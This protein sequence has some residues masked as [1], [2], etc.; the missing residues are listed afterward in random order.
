MHSD[1]AVLPCATNG[2]CWTISHGYAMKKDADDTDGY[3]DLGLGKYLWFRGNHEKAAVI[4]GRVF[5]NH[6]TRFH[7]SV[8]WTATDENECDFEKIEQGP[9]LTR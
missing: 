9:L 4:C 6:D 5:F 8:D 3:V 1:T 7:Q 2:H